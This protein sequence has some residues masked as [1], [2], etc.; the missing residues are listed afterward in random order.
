MPRLFVG[1]FDFEHRLAEP[2]RVLPARLARSNAEMASAWLSIADDGD[3]AWTP[4]EIAH[5]FW[6][7]IAAEGFPRLQPVADW[8]RFE[9]RVTLVPWGWTPDLHDHGRVHG[10]VTNAP[11]P[12]VV[13]QVNS[14]RWSAEREAAWSVGLDF[15]R[16]CH[17]L[18]DVHAA[19]QQLPADRVDWVLKAEFSMSG[20]ERILG[21]GPMRDEAIGWA[22]R[23]LAHDGVVFFEPWVDR[24]DEVGILWDVPQHGSPHL[25]GVAPM[26]IAHGGHYRGSWFLKPG[27]APLVWWDDA[28]A[29][30]ARAAED[31]QAAGYHG[32]LGIDAM[33][34]RDSDGS[35]RVRPLQ[36]VNARWTMGRLALGWR[37]HFPRAEWGYWWHGPVGVPPS[38]GLT[39]AMPQRP[40]EAGT[41][42]KTRIVRTS[43]ERIDGQPVQHVTAVVVRELGAT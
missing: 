19:I 10:W 7:A 29:I 14:R 35:S 40:A 22:R 31:A 17:S 36:D 6:E 27:F 28:V 25:V 16:V 1:N 5:E 32:P 4:G 30:T 15:A 39:S 37:R 9:G 12:D 41:P 33:Q 13:R 43:P 26:L 2:R 3:F 11:L 21:R 8:T 38:G 42:T 20:R 23:R 18:E 34:Y 24:L